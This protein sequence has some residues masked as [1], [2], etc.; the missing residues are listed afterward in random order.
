M[1]LGELAGDEVTV[2]SLFLYN[3]CLITE[4]KNGHGLLE[5]S[6]PEQVDA[7]LISK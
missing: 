7:K 6:R 5:S 4:Y 1:D 3:M 2:C